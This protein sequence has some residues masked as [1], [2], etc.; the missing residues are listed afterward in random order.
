MAV[1]HLVQ[2]AEKERRPGD[3]GLTGRGRARAA[4]NAGRLRKVGLRAIVSSP[5]R[6]ARETASFLAAATGLE[7]RE[8][9]RLRERMNWDGVQPLEAFLADWA[10]SV[11]DRD[12]VPDRGDSF[13]ATA[14][15]MRACL[16]EPA[17]A[18]ELS[19]RAEP[20]ESADAEPG[21]IAVVTHG[22]ATVDLLRTLFGDHAVPAALMDAGVPSC[23]ITT[24]DVV[25]AVSGI[26]AAPAFSVVQI[27]SVAHLE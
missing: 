25:P 12:H 23:A 3:P 1:F 26:R 20:F 7:V 5:L 6:R 13:R 16:L 4:R 27:A 18:A 2:H 17:E 22:G 14:A 10:A 24:L 11:R 15:R 8:D 21:P 19:A 9:A